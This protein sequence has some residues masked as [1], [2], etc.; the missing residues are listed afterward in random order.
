MKTIIVIPA[1]YQSSRFPGKPLALINGI[2]M[3]QRVWERCCL[4]IDSDD[5]FVATDD[6]RIQASCMSFGAKVVRTSSS[7][8]TGTD[9]VAEV[10]EQIDADC[11]VNVQGDEPL[12]EPEAIKAVISAFSDTRPELC[13]AMSVI[14]DEAEYFSPNVPKVV[15]SEDSALMY[16][17]RAPIPKRKD[18]GFELGYKQVCIYAFSAVALS[19]FSDRTRKCLFE[20]LEDIEILRFLEMGWRVQMVEVLAGSIAV[21]VPED[22]G[23]V[24]RA[25]E[26]L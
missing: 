22:V 17:S 18:G 12:V 24:E 13:N 26:K 2:P 21:D 25:L 19:A 5:V 3:I 7:C 11:F 23:K 20:Q 8:L 16:M 9:R 15:F 1:R 6:D 4:A 10:A 14:T